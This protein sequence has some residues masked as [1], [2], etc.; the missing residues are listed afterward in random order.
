MAFSSNLLTESQRQ[1]KELEEKVSVLLRAF[2]SGSRHQDSVLLELWRE[3]HADYLFKGLEHLGP[4]YCVLDANR[5]WLCYWILHS[6]ALLGE[7]IDAELGKHMVDFLSRCQDP[8][9][10]Y[11][12]GPGQMAHLATTYAAVCALVTIGGDEAL[13]SINRERMLDFLLQMKDPLGGF[14]V[15]IN[16]EM[17]VRGCYTAIAVAHILGLSHPALFDSVSDY[18]ISCQ[19]YEG[20]IGGEP[21]SEAHG[22]YTY[23]GLAALTLINQAHLLDLPR[24][25]NWAVFRQGKVE[26]GFQGRVNKLVDGCYSFWQ[27]GLFPL[28]QRLQ[29]YLVCKQNVNESIVNNHPDSKVT[30][31]H[32]KTHAECS[33]NATEMNK[34]TVVIRDACFPLNSEQTSPN[35]NPGLGSD[36]SKV[37]AATL[38]PVVNNARWKHA[39]YG[40]DDESNLQQGETFHSCHTNFLEQCEAGPLFNA[41]ALQGYILLCCQVLEGGLRDKPGKSRDFYHTCYCLSGLSTAQ[42]CS[43]QRLGTPPLPC[44]V[45][46]PFSNLLEATHPLCNLVLEKYID[47]WRFY[48]RLQI[49]ENES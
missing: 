43:S 31:R 35:D 18:I 39:M 46:G 25:V 28:I 7:P 40:T 10:G 32:E 17:D 3:E 42:Y 41:Q 34:N 48:A 37:S 8:Q 9:G 22:G 29:H 47:A 24:L 30:N 36:V 13:A 33:T 1:Q 20:G 44:N 11:G 27:G 16:G 21:G 4:S 15:H 12:G 14:R 23:C 6:L 49:P 5:P 19:T 26:G 2:A 45:L 38:F